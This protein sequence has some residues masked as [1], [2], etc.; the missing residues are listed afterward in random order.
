MGE[1]WVPGEGGGK[2]G[3]SCNAALDLLGGLC[4]EGGGQLRGSP[5]P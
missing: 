4:L 5:L 2:Q 1:G 3:G